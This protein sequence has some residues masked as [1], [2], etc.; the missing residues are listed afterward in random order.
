MRQLRNRLVH[1]YVADLAEL[2]AALRAARPLVDAPLLAA[3]A[4]RRAAENQLP[5]LQGDGNT[6]G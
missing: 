1:E 4:F 3:Q 2:A 5:P 6:A